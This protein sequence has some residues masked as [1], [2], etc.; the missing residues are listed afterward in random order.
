M[1]FS[2]KLNFMLQASSSFENSFKEVDIERV[3][4]EHVELSESLLSLHD[5]TNTS[6]CVGTALSTFSSNFLCSI[7]KRAGYLM[8]MSII[9]Q[10]LFSLFQESGFLQL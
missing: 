4:A 10:F 9:S 5:L 6:D 8:I 1:K 2:F 7:S 3:C